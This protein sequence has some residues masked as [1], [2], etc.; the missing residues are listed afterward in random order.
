MK[1]RHLLLL[2]IVIVYIAGNLI[3]DRWKTSLYYGDSNGYYLHVVSFFVNQD[4]GDYDKTITTLREINP[5]SADPRADQFG[6]R[7]TEKGRYYIKYTLGVG[8]MEAP[9][10]L[11]AHAY[12]K[13]SDKYEANGWTRP[14]LFAIGFAIICYVL[15]GFNFLIKTL[16]MYFPKRVTA[17]TVL[18]IAFATNLLFQST[19][20]TMAH[21][22]LFFDYCVLIYLTVHFYKSPNIWKAL[23]I[24]AMVGLIALTRVPEVISVLVPLLW[25]I[26][27]WQSLKDR[28]AFFVKN[29]NFL[30]L[31]AI[32]F[33]AVFSIQIAYWYYVSGHL[34][35]NPYQGE[36]FN[37]LRPNIHKGWLHYANGWLIYTPIMAFSLLGW[38]FL[39]KYHP[40]SQLAIFAFVGLHSFIHYSYYAWTY[41]PGLGQR[42]M[43][44]TY[45]LLA[46]GLAAC[47]LFFTEKKWLRW[48]PIVLL[49][50]FTWLN[51]FQTWQMKKGLIWTE[52]GNKAFYWETFGKIKPTLNSVRAYDTRMF[53]PDTAKLELVETLVE[54]GFEDSTRFS[55]NTEFVHTGRF[56][57]YEIQE[58][59]YLIED[60]PLQ[61]VKPGDW[62]RIG[63]Y[64]YMKGHDRFWDR[65]LCEI[66]I[67]E[68]Y[69]EEGVKQSGA[70]I[71]I[72]G[73]IHNTDH[74]IWTTGT[75]DKYG[76]ASF[77]IR[78]PRK[79]KPSWTIKAYINNPHGQKLYLD[80]LRMEHF[81]RRR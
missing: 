29:Y 24:G 60:L 47:F 57:F 23:G 77:F 59:S 41:F 8:V 66:L 40:D 52:R 67:L 50:F 38:L 25:G 73:H 69:D 70:S 39:R 56:S 10:F 7:K 71:K 37:F 26:F 58:Y 68:I 28:V 75:I 12:A 15:I 55:V 33:L 78:V 42:P 48:L 81:R 54:E 4:V 76:E 80:D 11:A 6:I 36:G 16:E 53:Q 44:E 9:F 65:D 34:F 45:P 64:A 2:L 27:S 61:D 63:I 14:Y 18:A 20:L 46:F 1:Q 74:S 21:G 19:Y 35:F 32:G 62:L 30:L 49:G 17:L 13:I 22:F 51:L 43:V 79:A 5:E 3:L 31:A 72:S